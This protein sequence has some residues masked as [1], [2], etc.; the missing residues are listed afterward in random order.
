MEAKAGNPD[1]R[2]RVVMGR[3]APIW[4]RLLYRAFDRVWLLR[5]GRTPDGS[6][7]VYVSP[8]CQLSVLRASLPIDRVHA[9]FIARWVQADSIVWDVGGN[10]GLFSFPAALKA[11]AGHVYTF[12]PD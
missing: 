4:R 5:E 11:R 9:R 6:F 8:G 2:Q 10:M 3:H 12:E 1:C 7:K